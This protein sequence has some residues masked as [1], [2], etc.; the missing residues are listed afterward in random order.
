MG[1]PLSVSHEIVAFVVTATGVSGEMSAEILPLRRV[2]PSDALVSATFSETQ[3]IVP[4]LRRVTLGGVVIFAAAV[5]GSLEI[6]P[7]LLVRRFDILVS[8][9][10]HGLVSL[11]FG[12]CVD[13]FV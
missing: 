3:E 6:V 5:S 10:V 12:D 11:S 4:L 8:M 7:I 1:A 13:V 9:F 2:L